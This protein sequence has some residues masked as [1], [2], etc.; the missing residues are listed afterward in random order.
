MTDN[1]LNIDFEFIDKL[2][3]PNESEK[4]FFINNLQN[5]LIQLNIVSNV[6]DRRETNDKV[7]KLIGQIPLVFDLLIFESDINVGI[8]KLD[9]YYTAIIFS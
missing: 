1:F 6:T 8:K 4:E 5:N 3:F 9:H 2:Y 7:L